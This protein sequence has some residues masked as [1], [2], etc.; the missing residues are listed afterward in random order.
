M[1][2]T[3]CYDP[4]KRDPSLEGEGADCSTR[5]PRARPPQRGFLVARQLRLGFGRPA[6][7]SEPH[8][9]IVPRRCGRW[10]RTDSKTHCEG[11]SRWAAYFTGK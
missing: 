11:S 1:L 10:R 2:F 9:F 6:V 4:P 5:E 8:T 3:R 7:T